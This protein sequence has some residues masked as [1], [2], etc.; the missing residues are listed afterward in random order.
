MAMFTAKKE[1]VGFFLFG[2]ESVPFEENN[3]EGDCIFTG[4]PN[5]TEVLN[6]PLCEY[7]Q[8]KKNIEHKALISKTSLGF[9]IQIKN[10]EGLFVEAEL[11]D[12]KKGQWKPSAINNLNLTGF[13]LVPEK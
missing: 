5:E 7:L 4:V 2:G 6:D 11:N 1:H 9:K 8:H 10:T 13:C 3:W 12:E